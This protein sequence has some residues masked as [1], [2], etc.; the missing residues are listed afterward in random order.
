MK[1]RLT[2]AMAPLLVALA[3]IGAIPQVFAQAWPAKP[4]RILYPYSAG[5]GPDILARMFSVEAAKVLG[6]PI[7]YENRPGANGRLGIAA[8][9]EAPPDGYLLNLVNDGVVISQPAA[10]P[11]LKFEPGREYAAVGI[12]FEA[13][14]V[15]LM[16]P[17]MS[18]KDL[19]GFIAYA[20]A[21]PG[22]INFATAAGAPSHFLTERLLRELKLDVTL[23]GMKGGADNA[24]ST[25]GGH[26]DMFF[27]TTSMKQNVDTGKLIAL[28]SSGRERWKPFAAAP[29]FK[30]LGIPVVYAT[31]FPLIVHVATPR[32][33]VMKLHRAYE[34]ASRAPEVV[35]QMDDLAY[36]PNAA[37]TPEEA[38]SM[39]KAE[40]AAW[41]PILRKPAGK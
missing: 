39:I 19:K 22:K 25:L 15:M 38:T 16:R 31:T 40:L 36:S 2:G 14:L 20:R 37:T 1:N 7:V 35:K 9:R 33:I 5:S 11:E 21:N 30:E 13:P 28:A 18:F 24:T 17:D 29:T 32:D 27:S 4:L 10:D 34:I 26:T 23:V 6:Q 8:I 41:I 12:L 3:L